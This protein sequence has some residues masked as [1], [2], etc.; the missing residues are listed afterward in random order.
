[1]V[2]TL[3]TFKVDV[4]TTVTVS[5]TTGLVTKTFTVSIIP[6]LKS[7]TVSPTSVYGGVK[8]TGTVYLVV[9]APAGGMVVPL[10][11][12]SGAASIPASVTI[13]AGLKTA[14]FQI[15]TT[16]VAV[17]TVAV[18]TAGTGASAKS[19]NLTI[20]RPALSL[21]KVSPISVVG[22]STTLVQ[23][24]VTLSS[25]APVGGLTVTLSSNNAAAS[26]PASVV[27]PQGSKT[28]LVSV[29]HN[30][31]ANTTSVTLTA[32]L[33]GVNKTSVLTINP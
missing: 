6:Y 9:G 11:S 4:P 15:N 14:T 27:V 16:P 24:T 31:V 5:A 13:A 26:V 7:V 20:K 23:F 10:S 2:A 30:S 25:A 32:S 8:S 29:T 18:L 19:V 33:N 17:D 3:Q 21:A 12:S 28:A 1:V 22:G